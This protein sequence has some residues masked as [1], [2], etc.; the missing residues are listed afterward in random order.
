MEELVCHAW[1][2]R[3]RFRFGLPPDRAVATPRPDRGASRSIPRAHVS[4][5]AVRAQ[6][7]VEV[8]V[9]ARSLVERF[10]LREPV[11][12][13][14]ASLDSR[15]ATARRANV[16][17][18]KTPVAKPFR[19]VALR[20]RHTHRVHITSTLTLRIAVHGPHALL[21]MRPRWL[22]EVVTRRL[23][24]LA[25][26]ALATGGCHCARRRP[27]RSPSTIFWSDGV[28]WPSV[29]R[30]RKLQLTGGV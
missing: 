28:D 30:D 27:L 6:L 17:R 25:V 24:T 8:A 22:Y 12:L 21:I 13:G 23:L 10:R 18:I 9:R 19:K 16:D 11:A 2:Q 5:G 14:L 3:L 20:P 7:C 4:F 1:R 29:E 15:R 26:A